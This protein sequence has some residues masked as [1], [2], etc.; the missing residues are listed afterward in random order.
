MNIN[1]NIKLNITAALADVHVSSREQHG[2]VNCRAG[3]VGDKHGGDISRTG[4][5]QLG[6]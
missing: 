5:A 4:A 3:D 6:S 2:G 1:K